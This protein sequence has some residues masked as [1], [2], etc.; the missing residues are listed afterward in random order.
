[1]MA[2]LEIVVMS[3]VVAIPYLALGLSIWRGS[4]KGDEK[5]R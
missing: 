2:D 3:V 4:H 5:D 1:M